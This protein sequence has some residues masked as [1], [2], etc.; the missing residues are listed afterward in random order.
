MLSIVEEESTIN[1]TI[2]PVIRLEKVLKPIT[3]SMNNQSQNL[4]YLNKTN[5][6][7]IRTRKTA[8]NLNEKSSKKDTTDSK[9]IHPNIL[10]KRTKERFFCRRASDKIRHS[11]FSPQ[12]RVKLS[13]LITSYHTSM[14]KVRTVS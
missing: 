14:I 5:Y 2:K 9:S 13:K 12:P 3:D 8:L 10:F 11:A 4:A 1:E 7:I 6:K